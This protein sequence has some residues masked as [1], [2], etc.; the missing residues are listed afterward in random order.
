MS[1]PFESITLRGNFRDAA[2]V[3]EFF[4][5][6]DHWQ[7]DQFVLMPTDWNC[8]PGKDF[9]RGQMV[10]KDATN[11]RGADYNWLSYPFGADAMPS[12]VEYCDEEQIQQQ[13]A[14]TDAVY[15]ECQKHG[16]GFSF[17]I[18][19]PKFLYNDRKTVVKEISHLFDEY[20]T[21]QL[22]NPAYFSLLEAI[23]DDVHQRYPKM[24]GF[25]IWI[26]EGA[27]PSVHFYS[28]E[29][30]Q[31]VEEWL[32]LWMSFL[33]AYG[34]RRN[35][36]MKVSAHHVLHSR[37]TKEIFH[38]V[39]ARFPRIKI[40]ENIAWP[41]EHAALPFLD[42]LGIDYISDFA[43][44]SPLGLYF[45]LDT[46]FMGQ[47]R[48]PCVIPEWWQGGLQQAQMVG[49]KEVSGRTMF[50]DEYG[51]I[52]GWNL[53]NVDLFC[54][55]AHDPH[56]NIQPLLEKAVARR[57]SQAVAGPLSEVLLDVQRA[58]ILGQMINGCDLLDHSAFPLPD[59]LNEH[60]FPHPLTMKC[61]NDLFLPPGTKLFGALDMDMMAG[62]EWRQQMALVT[63]DPE[64]YLREKDTAI[65]M[66]KEMCSKI[67][68][69]TPN[70]PEEDAAFVEKSFH[71]WLEFVRGLRLYVEAAQA[72]AAWYQK[73]CN[74]DDV[75][76]DRMKTI[77]K[78]LEQSA[79]TFA[80]R[81]GEGKLFDCAGRMRAMAQC[82]AAP[83]PIYKKG[84]NRL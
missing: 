58:I 71:M 68:K 59:F 22:S 5:H 51:T 7:I 47:G 14:I 43:A 57:F 67:D 16:V 18:V 55:L 37:K 2:Q 61:T 28:I 23:F 39:L 30:F 64:D 24:D 52:D 69:I 13:L 8:H 25:E 34:L 83:E 21:F 19:V 49:T 70:M 80:G 66:I 33:D 72:H 77:S 32:P 42:F 76:L 26:A 20:G 74:K 4:S 12:L 46:E 84:S 10:P 48:I 60:Y 50:W 81:F 78:K 38:K 56:Q 27:G 6:V 9:F 11:W 82:L 15:E 17:L 29:D 73:G 75:Q 63:R 54:A 65:R 36:E 41:S 79:D 3:H 62:R 31:K 40:Y 45:L 1:S 53:L 44:K 35:L